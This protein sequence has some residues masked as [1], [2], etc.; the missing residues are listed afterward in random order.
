[1]IEFISCMK[2]VFV[3]IIVNAFF[4][5]SCTNEIDRDECVEIKESN[6][7]KIIGDIQSVSDSILI[8]SS[9]G[10]IFDPHLSNL[11]T[12]M[13][14]NSKADLVPKKVQGY[15]SLKIL[16]GIENKKMIFS[17]SALESLKPFGIVG[18]TIY[19]VDRLEVGYLLG[20]P[21]RGGY[22][23]KPSPYCG[24][25]PNISGST[26]GYQIDYVPNKGY[27]MYSYCTH[28]KQSLDGRNINLYAPRKPS[29]FLWEYDYYG[30]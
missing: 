20:I 12:N 9:F 27:F 29:D 5:V 16:N 3:Y 7:L 23:K 26:N 21:S 1:M 4:L 8:V 30:E 14:I 22:Y 13:L 11:E 18:G 19:I 10:D 24:Y 25:E 17:G 28:I 15:T 6:C 2:S